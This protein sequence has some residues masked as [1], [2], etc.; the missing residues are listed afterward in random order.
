MLFSVAA[1]ALWP[2]AGAAQDEPA[3]E[4][5]RA[6]VERIRYNGNAS[7]AG[8]HAANLV[9][10]FYERRE[11]RSAWR[12]PERVD[13]LL[14]LVDGTFA[15][16]LEPRDYHRDLI[17]E[18]RR[19][20][21]GGG[22]AAERADF[23]L[24]LT[25]ALMSLVHHRRLGKTN[26]RDQHNSWNAQAPRAE[27]DTLE[28]VEQAMAAPALETAIEERLKPKV[29][30]RR[31]RA[32]LAEYRRIADAG[33]W[34]LVPEGPKLET[35]T[36]DPRVS[37]LAA[38]LST[39]GDLG[40]AQPY[41]ESQTMDAALADAVRRFQARH[42][43]QDDG[44][45]GPAT[46]RALN[47]PAT[48]RVQQ[49]RIALERARWVQ[50][51]LGARF[52]AVNIAGF[53]VY[54]VSGG[55]L[56]WESR[57]V[58]GKTHQQT[59]VF[60]G[61]LQYL[62]FNPSWSVPYS[63]ATRELLPQIQADPGWF[64][65]HDYDLRDLSGTRIDPATVDWTAVS[66]RNFPYVLVQRPGP[67]NALG[68]VKF[69]FPNE[70]SVYLHDTPSRAL[71]S[72][73]E[74]AFSHGCIRVEDPLALATVLLSP[75]GWDRARIDAA[76]ASGKTATVHLEQPMPVLLLYSTAN[77]DP[78]GTVHFYRDIYDRDARIAAALDA[79]FTIP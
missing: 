24:L 48:M 57:V 42:G 13:A 45:V 63:I 46:L 2:A 10:A 6:A 40:D 34:P 39:T 30:Y 26:P 60:T 8:I 15:D 18:R 28:V 58:V 16:G 25:D 21:D 5:L 62:V 14:E 47:V 71:F 38:H 29:W 65:A 75:D 32:A 4:A 78:D 37:A 41:A 27:V 74:R 52:V 35:G 70:H 22:T 1:G 19:E 76:V 36:S 53:R 56:A 72:T 17:A 67:N 68:A 9:A 51:E 73:A 31:L 43:L 11:F 79:P 49:L 7:A 54:V 23:E 64:A 77:I 55:K 61:A 59:P 50:D 44:V 69:V 12:E 20:L 33:G 66:R 3:R